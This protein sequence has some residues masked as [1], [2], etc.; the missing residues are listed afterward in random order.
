MGGI[1]MSSFPW[2]EPRCKR[3]GLRGFRPGPTQIG[4]C[5]YRRWLEP[6]NLGFREQRDC[7]IY[8]AKTKALISFAV[9]AK[10]IC[11]FV[12]A[13]AKCWF[14]HDAAHMYLIW[15]RIYTRLPGGSPCIKMVIYTAALQ[16]SQPNR[17]YT[18]LPGVN[19]ADTPNSFS[20]RR[21]L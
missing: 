17:L 13:Y 15:Q 1:F 7:T 19:R 9:T 21:P 14:S 18:R 12:F 11:V 6:W 4:L 3:T 5:S 2:Y 8:V 16:N 20:H 10:L